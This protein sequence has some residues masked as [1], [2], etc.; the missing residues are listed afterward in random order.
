MVIIFLFRVI[1]QCLLCAVVFIKP[2][3]FLDQY[4]QRYYK[5]D[6]FST[7]SNFARQV[8]HSKVNSSII[9]AIISVG[10]EIRTESET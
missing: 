5:E 9:I 8:N 4:N 3:I 1:D 6:K 2:M 7:G 10:I